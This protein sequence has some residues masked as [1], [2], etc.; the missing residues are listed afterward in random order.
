MAAERGR[1]VLKAPSSRVGQLAAAGSSTSAVARLAAAAA[2]A[3]APR[4]RY[5]T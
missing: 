3:A 5:N 4:P 1:C 2:T